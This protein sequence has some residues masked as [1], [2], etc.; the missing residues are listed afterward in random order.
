MQGD[1]E[2]LRELNLKIGTAEGEGDKEF[3]EEVQLLMS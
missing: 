2:V 3:L 1:E